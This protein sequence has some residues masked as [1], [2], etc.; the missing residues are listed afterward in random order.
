MTSIED[1][2]LPACAVRVDVG[3]QHRGTGFFVAPGKVVTCAHVVEEA[4]LTSQTAASLITIVSDD[5]PRPAAPALI[6][7]DTD[8]ALLQVA[9]ASTDTCVLLHHSLR[10]RDS[11]HSFGFPG[12]HPRGEPTTLEAEG[13]TPDHRYKVK[14]GQVRG[15]LSGSPVLN[16]RTGA[17]CGVLKSTRD[18]RTDIGGYAIPIAELFRLDSTLRPE[19]DQYHA[20]N[21]AWRSEL[22]TEQSQLLGPQPAG[23]RPSLPA[24]RFVVTVGTSARTWSVTADVLP[25]DGLATGPVPV[26]LNRVRL[27]VARLFRDWAARG[28]VK[29]GEQIR[30]LGNILSRAVFPGDVGDRLR[31]LLAT[32]EE[33]RVLISLRFE[34][35]TER[36]LVQLPWEHLYL[37]EEGAATAVYFAHDEDLGF[38]RAFGEP[39]NDSGQEG[40]EQAPTSRILSVLAVAAKPPAFEDEPAASQAA[41]HVSSGLAALTSLG[42]ELQGLEVNTLDTPDRAALREAIADDHYDVVHYVGLGRF[43]D[44]QDEILLGTNTR[45]GVDY[46]TG[47]MLAECVQGGGVRLVVLEMC[48]G[49]ADVPADFAL[50]APALLRRRVDA[51]LAYQYALAEEPA[52]LFNSTLYG[53]LAA[54]ATVDFAVQQARNRLWFALERS[55]RAAVSPALFLARPKE[56]RLTAG[57]REVT[58]ASTPSAYAGRG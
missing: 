23:H 27:E 39:D 53:A 9:A 42:A 11:L 14:G 17:V 13:E 55:P 40:A 19:N 8:L 48:P 36:D 41:R 37:P 25:G 34:D 1:E 4:K 31:D 24:R 2:L 58:V 52:A 51:V 7:P 56:L 43:D 10:S 49:L 20:T 15:G 46:Y 29:E 30:L 21:V 32:R 35:D 54:G 12:R 47:D 6:D 33:Q 5:Q 3:G 45:A 50:L 28:R 22:T 18:E 38:V 26:D 44:G 16:L 57:T